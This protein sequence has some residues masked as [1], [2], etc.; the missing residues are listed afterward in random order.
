M[1]SLILT[2]NE[3]ALPIGWITWQDAV[4]YKSK[5]LILWQIGDTDWVKYGGV[6]RFTGI[7]SK[8]SFSS[9]IAIESRYNPKRDTPRLS[10]SNL[11]GRD[12]NICAYCGNQFKY[13]FLTNDHIIPRSK[14]G[15]HTWMNCVTACKRCNNRKG[16]KLLQYTNMELLYLPYV[17]SREEA[18][19][20][21]N[22]HILSDQMDFLQRML[23][24]HSRLR[25]N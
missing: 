2:L 12:L 4:V 11:F 15:K 6:N 21:K 1:A 22:R 14:G 24:E 16:K 10:N 23:P 8:I 3:N 13:E 5:D 18:L 9:I 7:Q 17:P 25:S 19:I 20:L